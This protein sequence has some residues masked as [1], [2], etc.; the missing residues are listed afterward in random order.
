M[1]RVHYV[2]DLLIRRQAVHFVDHRQRTRLVHRSLDQRHEIVE[3]HEQA[4][5]VRRAEQP[6]AIRQFLRLH[7]YWLRF[8]RPHCLWNGIGAT[9]TF[10]STVVTLI[11]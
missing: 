5:V 8:R 3:L 7:R 10:G 9:F 6:H 1:V 2:L 4:V 11:S